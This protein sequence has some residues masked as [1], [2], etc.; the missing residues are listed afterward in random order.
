VRLR[1]WLLALALMS[2]PMYVWWQGMP[3]S[4][5]GQE[6]L[7]AP[8]QAPVAPQFVGAGSCAASACHN[9]HIVNGNAGSEYAT[10]ITR[11]GHAKAYEVLFEERSKLIQKHLRSRAP[12]HEEQRCLN[13]HVAPN[14]EPSFITKAPYFK[15]DGVSCES[16]HGPAEKWLNVHQLPA[17]RS[18]NA[19][20]K[21]IQGMNDTQSLLGRARLCVQCHVGAP[22]RDVDHDLIAAGHP[23]LNFEFA[24]FHAHMPRHWPDAKDRAGRPD[25]EARAWAIGQLATAHAALELLAHRAG[26]AGKPWPEFAEHDC[27][28]CHHNL[29]SPSWR[30]QLGYGKRAPGAFPW[31]SYAL[32][33]RRALEGY[34][35]PMDDELLKFIEQIQASFDTGT[36][37]RKQITQNARAAAV[38]IQPRLEQLERKKLDHKGVELLFQSILQIDAPKATKSW[39]DVTR[40]QLSL[41]ALHLARQDMKAMPSLRDLQN[42]ILNFLWKMDFPRRTEYSRSF[43][44]AAIHQRLLEFRNTNGQRD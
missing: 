38:L 35:V 15:T 20:A 24:A 18:L 19:E 7:P 5:A 6:K 21:K 36:P 2:V 17:W 41:A 39:D 16:C 34:D 42:P 43:E 27:L 22:G 40:V 29:R 37:D 32:F 13:C 25:F 3:S 1:L 11:D 4:A 30:Q 28:A 9:G 14:L 23:R 31:G 44:P 12:A 8:R 33:N 10:W 26:D